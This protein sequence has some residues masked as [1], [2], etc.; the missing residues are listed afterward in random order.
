M[1]DLLSG[2]Y[3]GGRGDMRAQVS[4]RAFVQAMLDVE[5]ALSRALVHCG[6]A[7]SESASELALACDAA[8]FDLDALARSTAEKGTPV[9]ALLSALRE[10]VGDTAAAHLHRGATSQDIVDSAIMLLARR[11]LGPLIDELTRAADACAAL[12]ER[13]RESLIVGRTLLQQALPLTFGLKAAQWLSGLDGACAELVEVRERVLAVQLG[14]AVGTLAALGDH[15]LDVAADV[16]SQLG[17]AEPDLPWHTIRLRPAKLASALGAALG[18]MAKVARDV[19]LL[20]Q[21]E[22]GEATEGGGEGRGG[23]ST[24]PHKRNPV[25]AVS[26]LA[27]A[28]RGPGLVATVL[29]SMAQEHERAAGAWQSEWGTLTELLSLTG[30]AAAALSEVLGSL[31]VDVARMRANLETIGELVMTESVATALGEQFGRSA[32]QELV[33]G[34]ATRAVAEGR[35]LREVLLENPDVEGAL[36]PDGIDRALDQRCYLGAARELIDRALVAHRRSSDRAPAPA[37]APAEG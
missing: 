4:D 35:A 9:P 36:G 22:V 31:D 10:R 7:P 5:L 3:G 24:M 28:Q 16:A 25:G 18:V 15:G 23:S 19:V 37:P 33:Q 27:S 20:A 34:A 8:A 1:S 13:H 26:V 32:A 2:L 30:G 12:A 14:G 17:L 6:L 29:A 11:A 21:T